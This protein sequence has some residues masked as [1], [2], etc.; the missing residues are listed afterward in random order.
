MFTEYLRASNMSDRTTKDGMVKC[1]TSHMGLKTGRKTQEDNRA[2]GLVFKEKD[3]KN[4]R[5]KLV[6]MGL[7]DAMPL[8]DDTLVQ[9]NQNLS[10]KCVKSLQSSRNIDQAQARRS[11]LKVGDLRNSIN[12]SES[13]CDGMGRP[14]TPEPRL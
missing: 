12:V 10:F 9:Y 4:V 8:S 7:L 6:E 14:N 5:T 3:L 13:L 1:L 2:R 11:C